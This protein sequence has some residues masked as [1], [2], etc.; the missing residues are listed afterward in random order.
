M[1]S[2]SGCSVIT[3][4]RKYEYAQHKTAFRLGSAD[5]IAYYSERGKL[6]FVDCT[7]AIPDENKVRLLQTTIGNLSSEEERKKSKV[8]GLIPSPRDCSDIKSHY[9]ED[10]FI[11]DKTDLEWILNSLREGKIEEA[12]RKFYF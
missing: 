8:F 12:R 9:F 6:C 11:I 2:L 7:T 4:V 3:L 10:I 1:L 5:L